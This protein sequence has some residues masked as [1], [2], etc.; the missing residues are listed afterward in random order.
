VQEFLAALGDDTAGYDAS[1]MRGFIFAR[2]GHAR[3][4]SVE[5]GS[6]AWLSAGI[7]H[8]SSSRRFPAVGRLMEN[9]LRLWATVEAM[10]LGR[11]GITLVADANGV[12]RTTIHAGMKEL[13]QFLGKERSVLGTARLRIRRPGGGR[14]PL[15]EQQPELLAELERLVDPLTRGDPHSLL[16]GTCK[17]TPPLAA[18]LRSGGYQASQRT[19]CALLGSLGYRL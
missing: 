3:A 9:T 8:R 16:R 12:S 2:V 7:V 10:S 11:D 15:T 4:K 19:V 1:R 17:S 13:E 14:K 6:A 5:C 18:E